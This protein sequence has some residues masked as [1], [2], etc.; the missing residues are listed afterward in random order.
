MSHAPAASPVRAGAGA[1]LALSIA[2]ATMFMIPYSTQAIVPE[3]GRSLAVSPAVT[4]LTITVVVIG[5][6]LGAWL[7][8]PLSDRIGRREVMFGSCALLAVPTILIVFVSGIVELLVLRSL[9]GLLLPGLLTVATAYVYEAFPAHRVPTVVGIYTSALVLGGFFG[10]TIPAVLVEYTGWRESLAVLAIPVLISAVLVRIL[11]P[12]APPPPKARSPLRALK[13]HLRNTPIL[14]NAFAAGTTF[15]AFVGLF[16]VLAYRLESS[17]FGMSHMQV[18]AFYIVW[19][20]GALAPFAVRI[21]GH[22]GPRRVL[23]I[24]PVVAA[25]GL[26]VGCIPSLVPTIVGMMVMAGSL[27]FMV[28]VAQLLVP[29]LTLRD[30]GSAMSL[31]LT[32][33]Y[34]LG[35]LG[36]FVIGAAWSEWGWA[37]AVAFAMGALVI[38]FALTVI[39]R[40]SAPS[41]AAPQGETEPLLS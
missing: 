29:Q 13:A 38:A 10:R 39:L 1:I 33:Y 36:P 14:L 35:S 12:V 20:V 23:P 41:D 21:A 24:F 22:L 15:F 31:H 17:V 26:L 11:L 28:G 19:L 9:Q 18:G 30:R 16:S 3:I 40:R 4:G 32:I 6:A 2:S 25:A 5:I 34:L 7:M 27:F 37:G 8:G